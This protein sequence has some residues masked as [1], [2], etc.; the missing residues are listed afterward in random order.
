MSAI[1]FRL[2]LVVSIAA[3][4]IHADSDL[5]EYIEEHRALQ[6]HDTVVVQMSAQFASER[7]GLQEN[8]AELGFQMLTKF[9][10]SIQVICVGLR[11]QSQIGSLHHPIQLHGLCEV[12]SSAP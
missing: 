1:A 6:V 7:H 9:H 2:N 12:A 5:E 8:I 4:L 11:L 3:F 10:R